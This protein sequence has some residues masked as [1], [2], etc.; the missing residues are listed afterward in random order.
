MLVNNEFIKKIVLSPSFNA[1][2]NPY[3]INSYTGILGYVDIKKRIAYPIE[4]LGMHERGYCN[5][6][7]VIES[8]GNLYCLQ[9]LSEEKVHIRVINESNEKRDIVLKDIPIAD[10]LKK[11]AKFSCWIR[12]NNYAFALGYAYPSIVRLNLETEEISYISRTLTEICDNMP[13]KSDMG[14]FT[15]VQYIIKDRTLYVPFLCINGVLKLNCDTLEG[16]I[17][18][19]DVDSTGFSCIVE[20]TNNKCLL[21]G[22]GDNPNWLY[23]WNIDNQIVEDKIRLQEAPNA[24]SVKYMLKWDKKI[25]LFPWTN[26]NEYNLDI[27]EFNENKHSMN[28]TH[29]L[30][31]HYD[32]KV[33]EWLVGHEII[34]ACWKDEDTI[35]YVTGKDLFWHEY[36][37]ANDEYIEY[38][39]VFAEV[40]DRYNS[41]I[42]QYCDYIS[43]ER[44]QIKE[45][46]VGLRTF[47]NSL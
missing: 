40:D 7:D 6:A 16:H 25:Y 3:F 37:V 30:E 44:L 22:A 10:D 23:I 32:C 12:V 21:T 20:I 1:D 27:W 28:N 4:F 8:H 46:L 13:L 36:N 45:T 2:N 31:S 41:F 29:L 26:W 15:S 33:K 19:L 5:Y 18:C 43:G 17:E 24:L 9:G 11:E 38:S 42:K 14:F 39:V 34:Y 35:L 47:L